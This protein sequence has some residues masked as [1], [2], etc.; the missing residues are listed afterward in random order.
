MVLPLYPFVSPFFL[1]NRDM[2]LTHDGFSAKH[3]DCKGTSHT[4]PC[5][6]CYE[7][8]STLLKLRCYGFHIWGTHF[9]IIFS[10]FSIIAGWMADMLFMLFFAYKCILLCNG[11]KIAKY[12]AYWLMGVPIINP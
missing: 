8:S 3:K 11:K 7:T 2:R 9:T 1:H 12:E 4:M 6:L 5:L 10:V